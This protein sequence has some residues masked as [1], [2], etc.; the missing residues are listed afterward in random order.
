MKVELFALCDAATESGGKL[1]V[2]GIFDVMVAQDLPFFHPAC[3]VAIRLRFKR[4]ESGAHR[5]K[6]D[7]VDLDGRHAVPSFETT[8]NVQSGDDTD[9]SVAN[10]LLNFQQLRFDRYGRYSIDLAV[11][12]RQEG[13]LPV[14][15]RP[16]TSPL[17][18]P[19][20]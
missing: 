4:I 20:H 15:V 6:L 5:V 17:E 9:S 19:T 16:V 12:G 1:N 14:Y 10:M 11:D 18:K 8:V 7:I 2:L 13:A 3:A